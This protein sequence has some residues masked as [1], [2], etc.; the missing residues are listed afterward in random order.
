MRA[1]AAVSIIRDWGAA[2]NRD[3]PGNAE[4]GAT[5]E[6][7]T[8]SCADVTASQPGIAQQT[9]SKCAHIWHCCLESQS[10]LASSQLQRCV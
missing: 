6:A 1:I 3:V 10:S 9:L 5:A 7:L 8:G 2:S 4:P